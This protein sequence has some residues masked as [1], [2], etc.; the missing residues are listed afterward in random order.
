MR[1]PTTLGF[2]NRLRALPELIQR[3]AREAYRRFQVDPRHNSLQF[4]RAH[5]R[6]S[7]YSVRIAKNY[8]A[9]G[10]RDDEG[11]LWFWVGSHADYDQ[12]LKQL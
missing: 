9:L 2:R 10:K 3:A 7:I 6:L 1:S 5:R 8:R 12:T 11:M 4:K